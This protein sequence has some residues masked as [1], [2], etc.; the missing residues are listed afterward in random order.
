[1][2]HECPVCIKHTHAHVYIY[3]YIYIIY[4]EEVEERDWGKV[5]TEKEAGGRVR[6]RYIMK[7]IF[8][9]GG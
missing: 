7:D 2:F 5:E 9:A 8:P 1:M 4:I 6:D 3:I